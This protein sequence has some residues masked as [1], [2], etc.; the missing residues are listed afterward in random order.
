MVSTVSAIAALKQ[1]VYSRRAFGER[2]AF[3]VGAACRAEDSE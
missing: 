2:A 3:V 1:Y